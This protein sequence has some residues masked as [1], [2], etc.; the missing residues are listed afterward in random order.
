MSEDEFKPTVREIFRQLGLQAH[1]LD[2]RDNQLTPDFEVS[3][4]KDKYTVELKTKDDD[5]KEVAE[6]IEALSRGGVVGK[7]VPIGPR[8]RL[9]GLIRF[10][11][12]QMLA[13][14]PSGESF[15]V[16]WL[17]SVGE[18]P[19]FHFN[20]FR[21]TLFGEEKLFSLKHANVITCFYF[22]DSAFHSWRNHLDGAMLTYLN[23][24]QLCVNTL[25]PR[26]ER[27]RNSE[28]VQSMSKGLCDPDRLNGL[29]NDV[30]VTDCPIDRKQTRETLAYLRQK[31]GLEHLQDIPMQKHTGKILMKQGEVA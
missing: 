30:M 28:L 18:D 13:H 8:N 23:T 3:G 2:R 22:H 21:A 9:A 10:G 5:P 4:K 15:R 29:G 14:D 31:Y 20:R 6:E 7:S 19:E 11:V 26:V 16:I 12:Q 17:H 27:F 24:A 1:D 25:S